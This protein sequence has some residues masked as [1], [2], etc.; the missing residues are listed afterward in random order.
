MLGELKPKGPKGL[1]Y[2]GLRSRI[3]L[4]YD[5]KLKMVTCLFKRQFRCNVGMP[6]RGRFEG[7]RGK[8][9]I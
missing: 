3:G 5:F 2:L 4:V 9:Q 8:P 1:A 7:L 6:K